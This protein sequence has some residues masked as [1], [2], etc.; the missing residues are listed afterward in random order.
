MA[1]MPDVTQLPAP[2]GGNVNTPQSGVYGEKA[3]LE[4][5]KQ[6]LPMPQQ[7]TDQPP[8]PGP[9]PQPS[10]GAG[11]SNAMGPG[12]PQAIMAPTQRPDV[13][14]NTPLSQPVD[15]M[16]NAQSQRQKRLVVLD[17]LESS[18]NTSDTTREWIRNYRRQLLEQA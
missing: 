16:A 4:R 18:P 2:K 14:V 10:T 1:D 17:A 13:S 9:M 3:A 8:Q 15:P 11:V 6:D 12:V 7:P 5:L